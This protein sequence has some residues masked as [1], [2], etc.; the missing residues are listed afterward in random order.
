M[1]WV[2]WWLDQSDCE[3]VERL[4]SVEATILP[5]YIMQ[6]VRSRSGRAGRG[7][8]WTPEGCPIGAT[9]E[10]QAQ[11]VICRL[12]EQCGGLVIRADDAE[13]VFALPGFLT[14]LSMRLLER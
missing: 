8:L 5:D 4:L 14:T 9:T 11:T 13:R 2:I 10:W 6:L 3:R 12:A 7:R 1:D